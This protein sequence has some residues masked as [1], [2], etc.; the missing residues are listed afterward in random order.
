MVNLGINQISCNY[1]LEDLKNI[2]NSIPNPIL[3]QDQN[4]TYTFANTAFFN[5]FDLSNPCNITNLNNLI[6]GENKILIDGVDGQKHCFEISKMPLK[7]HSDKTDYFLYFFNEVTDLKAEELQLILNTAS[8][9]WIL[10]DFDGTFID[11]NNNFTSS[12]GWSKDDIKMVKYQDLI[13]PDDYDNSYKIREAA[14]NSNT[15]KGYG[16]INRYKCKNGSYK[17]LEWNWSL[18]QSTNRIILTAKDISY[19]ITLKNTKLEL[20]KAIELG[21]L[22]TDFFANISHEFRTPINIILTT[23]QL[24]AI[25]FND[26]KSLK[27]NDDKILKYIKVITQ[28]SY[29][30]LR[31]VN[32]LL[33]TTKID[34]NHYE[35]NLVYCNIVDLIENIVL[36]VADHIG[37]KNRTIIFDTTE[38][39]VFT[40]CDPEKIE[41]IMLNLLSN[42]VKFTDLNGIIQVNLSLNENIDK[43]IVS[44]KDDG[45]SIDPQNAELIFERFTQVDNLLTRRCEGSGLGLSL[46]KSLVNMH[47]GDVWANT[48]LENGAEIIFTIPITTSDK[49]TT[50]ANSHNIYSKMLGANIERYNIEFSDIY[51]L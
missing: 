23:I 39:E 32:N 30:L 35:L 13:H 7:K 8:D 15:H 1:D 3:A 20:E 43:L 29:R 5:I 42:A 4:N 10:V 6:T 37:N 25:Y 48:D 49:A 33:D 36:S 27:S 44:V 46:V 38:E 16:L 40:S 17:Y 50:D 18:I 12:L 14:H 21:N 11:F 45:I 31:L 24:I 2:L 34:E 47:Q 41:T 51:N 19:K 28:N 9:L 26:C 22:K